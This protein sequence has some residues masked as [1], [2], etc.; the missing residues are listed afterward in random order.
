MS[1]LGLL[2]L[3]QGG[4]PWTAWP[5]QP[6]VGDT[7]WVER[8]VTAPPG[9]RVRAGRLDAAE[10]AEPLTDPMT[11]RHESGWLV[12]YGVVVW[13]TGS[14]RLT[15]P[16]VWRLGP[17]GE[18][19]SLPASTA[20]VTVRSVLPD[21]VAQPE[22]RPAL[23]PLWPDV[24]RPVPPLLAGGLA[25]L[26]LV[27]AIAVRRRA[28][29]ALPQP[30]APRTD[31]PVDDQRW[32]RAG[33][34]RAVAARAAGGLRA[35]LARAVPEAHPGLS[36]FE[37]LAIAARALPDAPYREL[38]ALLSALDQ[39]AFAAVHGAAVPQLAEQARTWERRLAR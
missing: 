14:V 29:R 38:A 20:T 22:P 37:A 12:R 9:W 25:L 13:T 26:V 33:E 34:P 15:F 19:D 39:V 5:A 11:L 8:L 2:L 7:V 17:G 23:A 21:E 36:T 1:S 3:L 24:R 10:N 27:A 18:A 30:A 6:T 32:L 4:G 16:P 28:P 35:A 31:P